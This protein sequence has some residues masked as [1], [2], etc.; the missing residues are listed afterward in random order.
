MPL[1]KN[2]LYR[3][4]NSPYWNAEWTDHLGYD[5]RE[6]T[7]CRDKKSATTWLA[8]KEVQRVHALAG[9]PVATEKS[10]INASSEYIVAHR[11]PVWSKGWNATVESYFA[12]RVIPHFGED[13]TMSTITRAEVEA[14]RVAQLNVPTFRGKRKTLVSG[15]TINRMMDAIAAFGNWC[16]VDGRNYHTVNPWA[17]HDKFAVDEKPIPETDDA[18]I[19]KIL[20][21]L[22][23]EQ[24]R[25][26]WP[27]LFEFVL[28]TGLRKSELG[29]LAVQDC[30]RSQGLVY[31]VSS[32]RRGKTKS[33]KMRSYPLSPRAVEILDALP[34]R[35]DGLV[36]GKIPD[37]RRAFKRAAKAVGLERVWLHLFR[38]LFAERLSERGA[39]TAEL[40]A[41][42]GWRDPRMV[43][44]YTHARME[45]LRMLAGQQEKAQPAH[46]PDASKEE[47]PGV[48]SEA[49]EITA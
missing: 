15:A 36:F 26:N 39:S 47:R 38:H 44:K 21:A 40:Q 42:G 23:S 10:L 35:A 8:A 37:P 24:N 28:E 41:A 29:R 46:S 7:R 14:F 30:F 45:R 43:E 20:A 25:F 11:A 49:P 17:G 3:R 9:A 5:H 2:R 27:L 6:S 33:G 31:V 22:H 32:C 34:K 13:R 4:K 1:P 48:S 16:L 12:L 18:L 19:T